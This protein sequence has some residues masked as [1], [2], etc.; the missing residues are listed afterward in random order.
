[1]TLGA[2]PLRRWISPYAIAIG[3]N[4]ALGTA[5]LT[6]Q[7][8]IL[9]RVGQ[10]YG[11]FDRD[12]LAV[13]MSEHRRFGVRT[14]PA[15]DVLVAWRDQLHSYDGIAGLAIEQASV[16][17]D[18]VTR[19][20]NAAVVD[21]LILEMIDVTPLVGRSFDTASVPSV[22]SGVLVTAALARIEYGGLREALG[23][24][25]VVNGRQ[26]EIIGVVPAFFGERLSPGNLISL[27]LPI[28]YSR[29]SSIQVLSRLR[30]GYTPRQAQAELDAWASAQPEALTRGGDLHWV[31]LTRSELMDSRTVRLSAVAILAAF[32][33]VGVMVSNLTHLLKAQ[34]E[35]QRRE[36]ATRWALGAGRWRL[37][38][39]RLRRALTLTLFAGAA[40]AG[41]AHYGLAVITL[42]LPHHFRFLAGTR[43]HAGAF[44]WALASGVVIVLVCASLF[45]PFRRSKSLRRDLFEDRGLGRRQTFGGM[46]ADLH[47]V[48]V[49]AASIVLSIAAYLVA[50][51]VYRLVRLDV[52]FEVDDLISTTIALPDWKFGDQAS[53]AA[54][55]ESI[56]DRLASDPRIESVTIA[57]QPPPQ[58]GVFL[59]EIEFDGQAQIG[60]APSIVASMYTGHNYFRT[61]RQELVAGRSFDEAELFNNAPVV[62]VSEATAQLITADPR[63]VVGRSIRFGQERCEIVGVAA[64]IRTPGLAQELRSLQVYWPLIDY[65]STMTIL[66]RTSSE[67]DLSLLQTLATFDPD[68]VAEPARMRTLIADSMADV[69]SLAIL[70]CLM[71]VLAILLATASIYAIMSNFANSQR[72]QIALRMAL[73]AN[74]STVRLLVLWRGISRCGVGIGVGLVASYP[75]SRL[76]AGYLFGEGPD[77]TQARLVA[78]VIVLAAAALATWLPATRAARTP[79]TQILKGI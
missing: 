58:L 6:L 71:A 61:L 38:R 31:V 1:M 76:L 4:I 41:L 34:T 24:T 64:N 11:Y 44:G 14:S 78:A 30:P 53:R 51:S 79:P 16:S 77:S 65:R 27:V 10:T 9:Y 37:L 45:D 48:T 49:V 74:Q 66:V 69:R 8:S 32:I 22:D 2:G 19:I 15:T 25:L 62:I 56:L 20:L 3:V 26:M 18:G 12:Q 28:D 75:S 29:Y 57:S 7:L 43:V 42:A 21:P 55:F 17:S 23:R 54:A 63:T 46:L 40:A 72:G 36:L 59:G 13:L 52:G 68:I 60:Q 39:W 33:L 67:T 5:G 50:G 73:G 35:C 70:F 47:V